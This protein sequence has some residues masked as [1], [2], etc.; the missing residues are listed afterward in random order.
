[1]DLEFIC[2]KFYLLTGTCLSKNHQDVRNKEAM[3]R[4]WKINVTN[5]NDGSFDNVCGNTS[6]WGYT[7]GN[8]VGTIKTRFLGSGKAHIIFGNCYSE[9]TTKVLLNKAYIASSGPNQRN[10]SISF[11]YKSRDVLTFEEHNGGIILLTSLTVECKGGRYLYIA[12]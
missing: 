5:S 12:I 3:Q 1:M 11:D 4:L 8:D 6:F 9:G 10:V 7:A 2:G